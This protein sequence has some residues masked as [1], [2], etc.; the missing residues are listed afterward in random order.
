M[1]REQVLKP[2]AY[3]SS[4]FVQFYPMKPFPRHG[5][6]KWVMAFSCLICFLIVHDFIMLIKEYW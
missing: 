6:Q 3:P 2:F 4:I 5:Y 1:S